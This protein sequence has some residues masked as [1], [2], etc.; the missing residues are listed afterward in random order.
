LENQIALFEFGAYQIPISSDSGFQVALT[1]IHRNMPFSNIEHYQYY[2]ETLAA[3]PQYMSEHMA[4]MREGMERGFTMPAEVLKNYESLISEQIVTNASDS[5][6]YTPFKRLPD[7]LDNSDKKTLIKK[8]A[9]IILDDVVPAHQAYYDFMV[10][11]YIPRARKTI[12]ASALPNGIGYYKQRTQYFTTTQKM[13]EEIHALGLSE[14]ARIRKEMEQIISDVGFKGSFADFLEYLRT[15]EKFYAS[16]AESLLKEASFIAKKMD[17]K[18]PSLFGKLPRQPY[19]VEAVPASIAP[20]YTTGRYVGAPANSARAG[21]YWVNTYALEKRPLYVLEALTLHEAVPGHH[22]QIALSREITGLPEFRKNLYISAFGEGW[23]LYSEYLGI[24]AGFYRDPYSQFGRLTYE[25]WR[26]A[27]LVVDTG[28][29][30]K[31][32]TK[33][34][35]IKLME[36]NTALSTHNIQTEINR[37][38]AWPGQALSYK[39][40]ELTIQRL[41]DKA[42]SSLKEKFDVREF[43]DV[44]LS[45]GS[46]PLTILENVVDE[47]IANKQAEG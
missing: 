41:R 20:R 8:A 4:N 18:L 10:K 40:G 38:I 14:V 26:A 13:P 45:N 37:Y 7:S 11:E 27:R 42:Q 29:H 30:Y 33:E 19:T 36:E 46:I 3:I 32:W 47:Y 24:E 12:G 39:M 23:A 25:M 43:H 6:F 31:N 44:V 15:D 17:G 34:Q 35:A 22:L 2:L 9:R 1:F 16:D 5:V 21:A 28:M